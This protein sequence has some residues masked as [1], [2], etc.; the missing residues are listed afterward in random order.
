MNQEEEAKTRALAALANSYPPADRGLARLVLREYRAIETARHRGWR[1]VEIAAQLQVQPTAL[2]KA[3]SRTRRRV[4]A[5]DLDPPPTTAGKRP[6]ASG[7][8][9]ARPTAGAAGETIDPDS[10]FRTPATPQKEEADD[11]HK[12]M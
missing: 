12:W 4:L 9:P 11:D 10:G 1:W 5:G 7:K 2:A 6:T 8:S 3:Y